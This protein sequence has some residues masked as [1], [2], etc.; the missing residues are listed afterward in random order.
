MVWEFVRYSFRL[1]NQFSKGFD[2]VLGAKPINLL[3]SITY[4]FSS[5]GEINRNL[6]GRAPPSGP[7]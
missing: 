2:M 4:Q 3:G 1:L 6:G 7:G 5:S